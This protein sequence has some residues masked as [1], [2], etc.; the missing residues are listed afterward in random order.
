[1]DDELGYTSTSDD[2]IIVEDAADGVTIQDENDLST[3]EQVL[4]ILDREAKAYEFSVSRLN[5]KD[6]KFTMDEQVA[7]NQE[8][9]VRCKALKKMVEN[10]INGIE[11]KYSG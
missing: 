10:T 3:L 11:V 5:P 1:M 8:L 2:D 7:M 6:P 4:L 9:A